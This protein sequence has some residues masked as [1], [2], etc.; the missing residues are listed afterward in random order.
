MRMDKKFYK[1]FVGITHGN[2]Q[3][4]SHRHKWEDNF[5]MNVDGDL[6]Y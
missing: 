3:I 2:R 1:M 5:K 4:R 6:V